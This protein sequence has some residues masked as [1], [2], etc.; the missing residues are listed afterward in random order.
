MKC[1]S[2]PMV[3]LFN[4]LSYK[5]RT[6]L[7]DGLFWPPHRQ[8][9]PETGLLISHYLFLIAHIITFMVYALIISPLISQTCLNLSFSIPPQDWAFLSLPLPRHTSL[10]STT[11]LLASYVPFL[12]S[13]L[14]SFCLYLTLLSTIVLNSFLNILLKLWK[15]WF[16]KCLLWLITRPNTCGQHKSCA[17]TLCFL[18]FLCFLHKIHPHSDTHAQWHK[19]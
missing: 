10:T 19:E 2:E 11:C 7:L 6:P 8:W 15:I 4:T 5:F 16:H 1:Q 13:T 12:C 14:S 3:S 9:I 17:F 18:C